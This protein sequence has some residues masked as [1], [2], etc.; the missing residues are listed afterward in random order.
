M[1]KLV[2]LRPAFRSGGTVTAGNSSSINDGASLVLVV[3]EKFL[4]DHNLTPIARISG[5]GVA[6]LHPNVMGL[7]PIHATQ[8]LCQRYNKK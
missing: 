5:G 3:N 6:G 4:K 1:E 8:K 7:G 2:T